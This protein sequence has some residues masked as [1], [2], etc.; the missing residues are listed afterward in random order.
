[1]IWIVFVIGS[2]AGG[3]LSALSRK[4]RYSVLLR[5]F[6]FIVPISFG[7]LFWYMQ[8]K[9]GQLTFSISNLDG[10]RSNVLNVLF[11]TIFCTLVSKG[12]GV[13]IVKYI[14]IKR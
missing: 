6:S 14:E 3:V 8:Y 13:L 11:T 4:N 7:A 10:I 12:I 9:S 2:I 1:M 5:L